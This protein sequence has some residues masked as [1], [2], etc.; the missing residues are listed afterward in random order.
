MINTMSVEVEEEEE[1]QKED[2][3]I[4]YK[5]KGESYLTKL[6]ADDSVYNAYDFSY[7]PDKMT[8]EDRLVY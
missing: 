8:T 5:K 2:T 1:E 3:S 7:Y 6:E 4:D